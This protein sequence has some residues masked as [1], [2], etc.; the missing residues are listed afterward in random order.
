[1]KQP[2]VSV[3][4]PVYKAENYLSRCLD[5]FLNQTFKDFELIL[6]DDGSPDKSGNICDDYAKRDHRLVVIHKENGGVSSARQAGTDVAKG[7]Y[8][9]HADPDD[10]VEPNMLTELVEKAEKT[11]A[12]MVICDFYQNNKNS[13][14]YL[15]QNPSLLD[16][17]AVLKEL[18][19]QILHGS[20]CN[21]LIRREC[22]I[23]YGISFPLDIIRWEDLWVNCLLLIHPIKVV[24]L[25]KAFYHYDQV[26]NTESIVRVVSKKGVE[27]QI[28]FCERLT[29]IL[30]KQKLD[31]EDLMYSCIAATKVLMYTSNYYTIDEIAHFYSYANRM[32]VQ[33]YSHFSLYSLPTYCLS[34]ILNGHQKW[35]KI[36]YTIGTKCII[37]I[38]SKVKQILS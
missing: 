1:M 34:Q 21:K 27:S 2:I 29:K 38:G 18:L 23:K 20:C 4:I 33:Q 13:Q 11:N 17:H 28:R 32:F 36:V 6:V 31:T 26:V 14:I 25:P 37:P 8:V 9:I 10:W 19:S 24:H 22:I 30:D 16:H 35:G 7:L 3:I 5:S 12:D 15:S